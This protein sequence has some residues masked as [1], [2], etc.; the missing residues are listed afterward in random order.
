MN[1][2]A[3]INATNVIFV[4]RRAG[5]PEQTINA[6]VFTTIA[7]ELLSLLDVEANVGYLERFGKLWL[8]EGVQVFIGDVK[9]L[10]EKS[11]NRNYLT[12]I[13]NDKNEDSIPF[14]LDA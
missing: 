13:T 5:T 14:E 12:E 2:R 7:F 4:C 11:I 1:P 6:I 9:Y 8:R 3:F 10:K